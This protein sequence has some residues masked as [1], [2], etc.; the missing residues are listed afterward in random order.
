MKSLPAAVP[1][2]SGRSGPAGRPDPVGR[3]SLPG[4]SGVPTGGRVAHRHGL[5]VDPEFRLRRLDVAVVDVRRPLGLPL[6]LCERVHL[7]RPAVG[8]PVLVDRRFDRQPVRVGGVDR[9]EDAAVE[10]GVVVARLRQ[11]RLQVVEPPGSDGERQVVGVAHVRIQRS[12][13]LAVRRDE[14]RQE[15]AV[16]RV[17]ERVG[18][19]APVEV[20]LAQHQRHPRHVPVELGRRLGV[21][22]RYGRV[23][24]PREQFR[25]AVGHLRLGHTDRRFTAAKS[26]SRRRVG[27]AS[28]G[29]RGRSRPGAGRG[30]RR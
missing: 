14:E 4:R 16:A 13:R 15:A 10:L 8:N 6:L 21:A 30:G 23:V 12:R 7:A 1:V 27:R 17:E 26:P 5:G 3:P 2:P 25:L 22:A 18:E 11:P 29:R 28:P 20:R 9:V 19:V 24:R